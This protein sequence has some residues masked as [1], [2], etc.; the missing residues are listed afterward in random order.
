MRLIHFTWR[1]LV[2][3]CLIILVACKAGQKGSFERLR[4]SQWKKHHKEEKRRKRMVEKS[5]KTHL[6]NQSKPMRKAM[7]KDNRRMRRDKR[8][9]ARRYG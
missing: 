9:K 2:M 4:A 1:Q 3:V 5:Y 7:K 6:K 8:R